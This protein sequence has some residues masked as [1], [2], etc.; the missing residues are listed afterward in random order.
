ME[1]HIGLR[2]QII[3]L[4]IAAISTSTGAFASLGSLL[5]ARAMALL[6]RELRSFATFHG[7][8]WAATNLQTLWRAFCASG[9]VVR[10]S[11]LSYVLQQ[12]RDDGGASQGRASNDAR[13]L[14]WARSTLE[15][16]AT[17]IRRFPVEAVA[18]ELAA[19]LKA[20]D[21][22]QASGATSGEVLDEWVEIDAEDE[23]SIWGDVHREE[24]EDGAA[25]TR[26]VAVAVAAS[27]PAS[28]SVHPSSVEDSSHRHS[29]AENAEFLVQ[30]ARE[31]I[32]KSGMSERDT[33]DRLAK[34]GFGARQPWSMEV[35]EVEEVDSDVG[36]YD[37]GIEV[38]DL[39]HA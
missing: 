6:F 15:Q 26:S 3:G 20:W 38:V 1:S 23:S 25:E 30:V 2:T 22:E 11:F 18:P 16:I 4:A 39:S 28:A 21:A 37:D 10:S 29:R 34:M 8:K 19:V 14:R 17:R 7:L 31:T 27:A 35:E 5:G 13:R 32:V 12:P 33:T 24:R 36:E 9:A